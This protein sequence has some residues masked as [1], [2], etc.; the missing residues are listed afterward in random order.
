MT[1][2]RLLATLRRRIARSHTTG[3][4]TVVARELGVSKQTLDNIVTGRFTPT[5]ATR[6]LLTARLTR[7]PR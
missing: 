1:L 6:A 7:R 3:G 4:L 2:P 5:A